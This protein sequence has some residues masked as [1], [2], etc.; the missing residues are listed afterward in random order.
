M[1]EISVTSRIFSACN[2]SIRHQNMD[3]GIPAVGVVDGSGCWTSA[4]VLET[5]V[6]KPIFT[7]DVDVVTKL[8]NFLLNEQN[9][10][11]K[12]LLGSWGL[13]AGS[14]QGS[15]LATSHAIISLAKSAS[16]PGFNIPVNAAIQSAKQWLLSVQN[17]DGGWGVEPL[18]GDAG[19]ESRMVSTFIALKALGAC[20]ETVGTSRAARMGVNWVYSVYSTEGGFKA[21]SKANVDPC[22][23]ARACLAIDAVGAMH[24]RPNL[25]SEVINYITIS[26]PSEELWYLSQESYVP[27]GAAGQIFFHQNTTAELL[28]F[29]AKNKLCPAYQLELVKWFRKNQ[30]DDG[31]WYLGANDIKHFDTIMWSTADAILSLQSFL[32]SW[33]FS[34]TPER[35]TKEY[36]SNNKVLVLVGIV[37]IIEFL[38]IIGLPSLVINVVSDSWRKLP[39]DFKVSSIWAFVLGVFASIVAVGIATVISRLFKRNK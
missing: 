13:T 3:G 15:T 8:V 27:D 30:N 18:V 38:L 21:A 17:Q 20:N 12:K 5:L 23:T 25:L 9:K 11:P 33:D 22:S 29:L 39:E 10:S 24:E 16:F 31:S 19:S 1:D 36:R 6:S 26:K 14:K 35:V 7:P 2:F 34:Y 37:A 32:A 4:A 28:L